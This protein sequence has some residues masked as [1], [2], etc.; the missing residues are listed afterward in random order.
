MRS[1]G[2]TEAPT[3]SSDLSRFRGNV[4]LAL[5]RNHTAIRPTIRPFRVGI[6]H[7]KHGTLANLNRMTSACAMADTL[8][9]ELP[10][11][12]LPSLGLADYLDDW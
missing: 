2:S 7:H 9:Y 3:S 6:R 11:E 5:R 10:T 8:R 4:R 1:G 12:T